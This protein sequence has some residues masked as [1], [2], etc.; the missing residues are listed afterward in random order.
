MIKLT[1]EGPGGASP[2]KTP[3]GGFPR[4]RNFRDTVL[5][6]G[7]TLVCGKGR[8]GAKLWM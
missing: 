6:A 8:K 3:K 7:K 4:E 5:G 1:L 2:A